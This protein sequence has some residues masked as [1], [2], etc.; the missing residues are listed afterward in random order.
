MVRSRIACLGLGLLALATASPRP[1][2]AV[3]SKEVFF[4]KQPAVFAAPRTLVL[5]GL[6]E[7]E[8]KKKYGKFLKSLEKRGHVLSFDSIEN[9]GLQVFA[10]GEKLFE[11]LVLFPGEK[12]LPGKEEPKPSY[13]ITQEEIKEG[14]QAAKARNFGLTVLLDFVDQGGNVFLGT[15]PVKVARDFRKF[16]NECGV[17]FL[18]EDSALVDYFNTAPSS[19]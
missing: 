5:T 1:A 17:D 16:A 7:K 10:Y 2:D 13:K 18:K 14:L 8:A 9:K 19:S 11:N 3:V 6:S 4:A 12:G 15:S